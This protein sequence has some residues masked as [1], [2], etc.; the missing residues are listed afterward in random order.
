MTEGGNVTGEKSVAAGMRGRRDGA[1]LP[2]RC[3]GR[4]KRGN[5]RGDSEAPLL[6]PERR[7]Q[8]ALPLV[9]FLL[10]Y[11]CIPT[12]LSPELTK[13]SALCL[14]YERRFQS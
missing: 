5:V 2:I 14:C 1:C 11:V 12:A 13:S 9:L 6:R 8:L 10:L 7:G 3:A 4:Q